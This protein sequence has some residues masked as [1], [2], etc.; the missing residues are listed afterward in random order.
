MT[1]TKKAYC[2]IN[3]TLE[4]LGRARG[5]GFHDLK[6]IMHKIP[7]GDIVELEVCSGDGV[8]TLSCDKALC[9]TEDNLAYR[10]AKIYLEA[11]KKNTGRSADVCIKL[12]KI[13]PSGAGLG[14][15]SADAAAVL[16][17]LGE[18]LGGV[19]EKEILL[20]A[21]ELG[22][23]VPFCLERYTSAYCT[24][25]GE[26]CREISRLP[27]GV[28]IVIAKP[29]EGINTKGIYGVYDEKFGDNYSKSKSDDMEKALLSASLSEIAECTTNDFECVC[30]PRLPQIDDLKKSLISLG[31]VCS[32]MSG[33]GS[34]VFGLFDSE[35]KAAAAK[36]SLVES[37]LSEV[38]VFFP[39]DF[40]EM[41]GN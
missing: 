22:S 40:T 23:D 7:L 37:G 36:E 12:T 26:I 31:A 8:I 24:G 27:K 20:L 32:Q 15:G 4:I 3:L 9:D 30:I 28:S 16:D 10:A 39:E 35:K 17:A 19:T 41:Y 2:K 34:A 25:R 21:S 14:G 38:F 18:G 33:S 29:E 13:T 6:T 11:Y 5:D 1:V